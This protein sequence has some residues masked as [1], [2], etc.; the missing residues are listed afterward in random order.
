MS[1]SK[2]F[3]LG[4]L[5]AGVASANGVFGCT[6]LGAVQ[7]IDTATTFCVGDSGYSNEWYA[8]TPTALANYAGPLANLNLLGASNQFLIY[9]VT[10][11][12]SHNIYSAWLNGDSG[13]VGGLTFTTTT[14][15][16]GNPNNTATH[17][18]SAISDT[19]VGVA[20]SSTTI[21]NNIKQLFTI[22]N[23]MTNGMYID[24]MTFVEY[25]QYFPFGQSHPNLGTLNYQLVPTIEQTEVLGLWGTGDDGIAGFVRSGGACGGPG[26]FGCSTP[27]GYMIGTSSDV[28]NAVG[29]LG[30]SG[31]PNS[32]P[33]SSNMPAAGAI[34]W[35]VSGLHLNA[36]DSQAFTVELVP[37]PATFALGLIGGL[38]LW[39]RRRKV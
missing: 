9:D 30:L 38:G 23:Q 34:S 8:R 7:I 33:T 14:P 1:Y 5:M 22:T 32:G 19:Q 27:D 21:M 6:S 29:D 13:G 28:L 36:G 10:D 25:L 39:L 11:G 15:V 26:T 18:E 24:A 16:A 17:A 3:A 20:V 2:I 12:T 35:S 37:E 4:V 31:L